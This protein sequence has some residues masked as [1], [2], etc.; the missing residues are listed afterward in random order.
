MRLFE[1]RLAAA[2]ELATHLTYLKDDQPVV[3]GLAPSGVPIA[4]AIAR[5]LNAEMDVLLIERL[6]APGRT[7]IVGVVDEH[8]RISVIAS[9]ARWHH[10]SNQQL[11]GPAR[12]AFR[13]LQ[14]GHPQ[15]VPPAVP[16]ARG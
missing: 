3:L 5:R 13:G 8:G 7:E 16:S 9:T 10:V 2:T 1:N 4:D 12:E 15:L 14:Q 6:T 11:I